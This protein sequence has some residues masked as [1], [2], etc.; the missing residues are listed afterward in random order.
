MEIRSIAIASLVERFP[1]DDLQ[2]VAG[3]LEE[4]PPGRLQLGKPKHDGFLGEAGMV[5]RIAVNHVCPPVPFWI[6][7][8][9]IPLNDSGA[10]RF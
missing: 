3:P 1:F 4:Q 5:D 2:A 6:Q 9:E 10:E 7:L 8:L